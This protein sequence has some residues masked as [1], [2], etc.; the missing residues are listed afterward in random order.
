[1]GGTTKYARIAPQATIKG[2]AAAAAADATRYMGAARETP[3][4]IA[5]LGEGNMVLGPGRPATVPVAAK[6]TEPSTR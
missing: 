6:L 5:D 3:A 2:P 1:V 4:S